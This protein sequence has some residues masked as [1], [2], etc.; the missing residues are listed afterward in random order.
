MY[1]S[2]LPRKWCCSRGVKL[3]IAVTA[4]STSSAAV[5]R[6]SV[7]ASHSCRWRFQSSAR[8]HAAARVGG[9][10]RWAASV[11]A[12]PAGVIVENVLAI[13]LP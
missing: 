13:R 4:A 5:I 7:A 1:R 3:R 8:E 12:V 10:D 9:A 11:A 2:Q 6:L